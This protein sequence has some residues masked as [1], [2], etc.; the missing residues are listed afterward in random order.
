LV[1]LLSPK[2]QKKGEEG[3]AR[4]KYV[5]K[6]DIAMGGGKSLISTKNAPRGVLSLWR[7]L[8]IPAM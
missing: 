1:F 3:G 2:F 4:I 5:K 6:G 8:L 7:V